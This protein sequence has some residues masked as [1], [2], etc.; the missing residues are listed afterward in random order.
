MKL[1]SQNG[2]EIVSKIDTDDLCCAIQGGSIQGKAVYCG[3]Y[4]D[5]CILYLLSYDEQNQLWY[6]ISSLSLSLS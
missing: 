1:N 2:F 3:G 6:T 5:K 4:S